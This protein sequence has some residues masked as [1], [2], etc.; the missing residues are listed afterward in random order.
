MLAFLG[1][2]CAYCYMRGSP[3]PDLFLKARKCTECLK[4]KLNAYLT[5]KIT[6]D[7]E[8]L[9]LLPIQLAK[10]CFS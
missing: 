4:L 1:E 5:F 6:F 3:L 7:K 2:D 9:P 8:R 10:F